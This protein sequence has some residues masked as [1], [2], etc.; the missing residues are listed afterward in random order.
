MADLPSFAIGASVVDVGHKKRLKFE[1][2]R[3]YLE[4]IN[5]LGVG[6]SLVVT[7]EEEGAK[8]SMAANRYLWGV[9][10]KAIEEET[11]MP[12][13]AIHSEMCDRFLKK[14]VFY[15]DPKTN[16]TVEIWVRQGSSGLSPKA[17][18]DFVKNVQLHASEWHGIVFDER[19]PDYQAY[20]AEGAKLRGKA[21]A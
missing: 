17:F 2:D 8:R 9:V 4:F 7:I 3:A 21:A 12:K 19:D 5:R 15:V 10:Y 11:G 1:S 18:H 20:Q 6:T 13:E 14:Q 16:L